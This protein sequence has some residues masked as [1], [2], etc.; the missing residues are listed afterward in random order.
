MWWKRKFDLR[1]AVFFKGAL[2][3]TLAELRGI[4]EAGLEV[5][6]RAA[7]EGEIWSADLRHPEWG[8]ARLTARRGPEPPLDAMVQF[9][10]GVTEKERETILRDANSALALDVPSRDGDV[11]R[12]RKRFLRFMAASLGRDGVVGL[13]LIA[14]MFWPPERLADELQHDAALDIIQ[15]HVLHAVTQ[16]DGMWLHS[17]G[18]AEMGFVDFDV[19]RPAEELLHNQFDLLRS[20]A[21]HI[22][23]GS[24]SGTIEPAIGAQTIDLVDA[25]RFMGTAAPADRDLRD[26]EYHTDRR[27]VCCDPASS[28]FVGRFFGGKNLRPS[29]LLSRGMVEGKHLIR[30]SDLA[31]DL[32]SARARD[33]LSLLEPL[34]G[35]F[36]DM[37]CMAVAK[38][39]YPTDSG[40]GGREHLWFEV[41]G[42][43][44]S[45]I[46]GTLLNEPFDITGMKA[47]ERRRHSIEL[48]SDWAIVTPIGQL[49]PRTLEI[50]RKLREHRPEILKALRD[51]PN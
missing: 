10:S 3:P 14:Q 20:I 33:S 18:L 45:D 17:H 31:T 5:S 43:A 51:Q 1:G 46:D 40:N 28:G 29:S 39:G 36:E 32:T 22:V 2:A 16:P 47:G 44:G 15:M 6:P 35:E 50:A 7:G 24:T 41:H 48:L 49:T 12:D 42:V 9:A 26:A 38:I 37:K 8:N 4:T 30:F 25:E 11:L 21:F 23:E 27:V 13:D 34:R 19:L